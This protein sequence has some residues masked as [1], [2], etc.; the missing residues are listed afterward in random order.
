LAFETTTSG[1]NGITAQARERRDQRD[2]GREM[3]QEL[4]RLRRM[5]TSFNSSLNTSA[6][7]CASP[8]KSPKKATRFGPRRKLASTNDLTLDEREK[9]YREESAPP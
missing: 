7:G 4:V 6:N 3:E 8:G 9:R 5:T 1:D 2:H